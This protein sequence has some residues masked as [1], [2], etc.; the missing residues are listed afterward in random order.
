MT[1]LWTTAV[2]CVAMVLSVRL[3]GHHNFADIYLEADTIEIEGEVLEF[4]YKLS[5]IHI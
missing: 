3:Q 1:R 4:Q 5:L 2:L